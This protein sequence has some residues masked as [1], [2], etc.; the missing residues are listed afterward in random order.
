[1]NNKSLDPEELR[2]KGASNGSSIKNTALFPFSY[3]PLNHP[4]TIC[5]IKAPNG[6][7]EIKTKDKYVTLNKDHRFL[8]SLSVVC[9]YGEP[10]VLSFDMSMPL[11]EV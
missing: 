11:L 10:G 9:N 5:L 2:K 3:P 6:F 7:D 1:M 4:S 8:P